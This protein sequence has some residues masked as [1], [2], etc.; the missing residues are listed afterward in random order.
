[1]IFVH[2]WVLLVLAALP[3]LLWLLRVTPPAP[4][5]ETFPAVRLLLGLKATEETPAR[6]PWWLL[7][8]RILAAA[9]IISAAV[10]G[11]RAR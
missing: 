5:S 7:A 10:M 3:L 1:M 8:L 6:T 4:R 2:P 11:A 9:L